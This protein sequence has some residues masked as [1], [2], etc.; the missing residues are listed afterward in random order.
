MALVAFVGIGLIVY[1]LFGGSN[2]RKEYTV[3]SRDMEPTFALGQKLHADQG[4]YG[5]A[6]PQIGDVVVFNPP[7]G[8]VVEPP[9]KATRSPGQPCGEHTDIRAGIILIKRVV[10]GPGD[11]VALQGGHAVVNG[12]QAAE[13]FAKPCPG[14][15]QCDLPKP[16]TVPDGEYYVLGDNRGLSNDSRFWGPVPDAWILAKV[17]EGPRTDAPQS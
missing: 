1:L 5:S 10:A 12:K 17:T 14:D 16:I 8:A 2:H 6:D 9:C 7:A 15:V 11:T 4:A 13:T 3:S